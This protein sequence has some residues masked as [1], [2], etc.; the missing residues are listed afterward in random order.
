MFIFL[1][2]FVGVSELRAFTSGYVKLAAMNDEMMFFMVGRVRVCL[3]N[4][5]RPSAVLLAVRFV[6]P[7]LTARF[8]DARNGSP[9]AQPKSLTASPFLFFRH[10]LSRN[11]AVGS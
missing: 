6:E 7:F 1:L 11:D 4:G 2:F 10:T 3:K 9:R 8:G 5:N